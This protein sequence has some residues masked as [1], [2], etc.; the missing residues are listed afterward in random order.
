MGNETHQSM[1]VEYK[2]FGIS[3]NPSFEN[4][5]VF[6]FFFFIT[7]E[8]GSFI[9][10]NNM[11]SLLGVVPV[12]GEVPSENNIRYCVPAYFPTHFSNS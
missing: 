6:F 12:Q 1:R 10:E 11:G 9:L 5:S 7:K 3:I 4:L 2:K 8:K